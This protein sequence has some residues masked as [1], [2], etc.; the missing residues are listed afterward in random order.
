MSCKDTVYLPCT[1]QYVYVLAAR[2][3]AETRESI[4][5]DRLLR[6][7]P[8]RCTAETRESINKDRLLKLIP[9]KVKTRETVMYY[10]KTNN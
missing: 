3:T 9:N 2:C 10:C 5:K 8:A 6:L 7:N 1:R 4:D